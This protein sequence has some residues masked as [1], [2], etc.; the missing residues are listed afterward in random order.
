MKFY[1]ISIPNTVC[2][3]IIFSMMRNRKLAIFRDL[4]ETA[5]SFRKK[6]EVH[7]YDHTLFNKIL[8]NCMKILFKDYFL[9][10]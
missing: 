10:V 7:S 1:S 5:D 6:M 9:L 2:F 4:N 8:P 3:Y